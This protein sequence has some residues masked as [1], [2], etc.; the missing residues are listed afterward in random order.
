MCLS[1]ACLQKCHQLCYVT[2]NHHNSSLRYC[3]ICC[4][5]HK[6]SK[7]DT[8]QRPKL[9]IANCSVGFGEIRFLAWF[10]SDSTEYL[11]QNF[12]DINFETFDIHSFSFRKTCESSTFTLFLFARLAN[13]FDTHYLF[14]KN[15]FWILELGVYKCVLK[16]RYVHE[17]LNKWLKSW[18]I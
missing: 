16:A 3:I 1:A 5:V 4:C 12:N 8:R 11:N 15:I 9:N 13:L 17:L 18:I 10:S 7:W 2:C 6:S 14:R